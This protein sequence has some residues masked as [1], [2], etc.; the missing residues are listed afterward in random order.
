MSFPGNGIF[1]LRGEILT[2]TTA[3]NRSKWSSIA[4]SNE[5]E[6]NILKSIQVTLQT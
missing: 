2:I 5:E 6:G 3:I 4:A 1:I